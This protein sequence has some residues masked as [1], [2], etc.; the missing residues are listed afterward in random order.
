M[1]R[2]LH[3]AVAAG[4]ATAVTVLTYVAD[5]FI[6]NTA[7]PWGI[8]VLVFVLVFGGMLLMR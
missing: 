4:V 2:W 1:V 6:P 8:Y 5:L 3:L 7:F